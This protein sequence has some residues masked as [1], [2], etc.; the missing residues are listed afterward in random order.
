MR[1][2][3]V[4]GRT[5][6]VIAA[7]GLAVIVLG[8]GS[9][10]VSGVFRATGTGSATAQVSTPRAVAQRFVTAMVARDAA[11]VTA[12]I[13][14][15]DQGAAFAAQLTQGTERTT[16]ASLSGDPKVNGDTAVQPVHYQVSIGSAR[17]AGDSEIV[18][19][20]TAN[21]WCVTDIAG[22]A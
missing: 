11:T 12:L 16:A 7:G 2:G 13:C 9:L 14:D 20:R 3:W 8:F 22:A 18:L 4:H 6:W 10:W 19:R 17:Q 15:R 21:S 1:S 5:R